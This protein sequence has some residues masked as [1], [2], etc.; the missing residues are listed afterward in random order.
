MSNSTE[1]RVAIVAGC[2][3]PFVRAGGE[4]KDLGAVEM[5]RAAVTELI[6]RSGVDP[7]EV[8]EMVFGCVITPVRSPNVAREVALASSLPRDVPGFTVNRACA[9][10]NQAIVSAAEGIAC[11]QYDTAIAGGA[12]SLS[13]VPILWSRPAAQAIVAAGKARGIAAK[14]GA[15]SKVRPRDLLPVPPAIAEHSTGLTMGQSAEKMAKENRI[16]REEQDRFA[17]ASHLNAAKGWETGVLRAETVTVWAPPKFD[18]HCDRDNQIRADTTY[19]ALAKLPPVF[20]RRHGSVTAGNTSPLT[21]GA[22][23]VLLMAGAK[24]RAL[25]IEPLGY[26]RSYAFAATDPWGQLLMG[27][28]YAA[29]VALDRAN[30][31]LAEM[32]LIEMHEA[33]AVQVLSNIQAFE[34]AAFAREKLGRDKPLGEVDRS[35]LNVHGGSIALGHPFGATGARMVTQLLCELK[36]RNGRFGL[37]TVCAQGGMGCAMVL[38]R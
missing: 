34:S 14:V 6:A 35:K 19:E 1:R 23:A 18:R 24:A 13:E 30:L 36:R 3:T 22:A 15:F 32:D 33:F 20:D 11:G 9:S 5:G 7:R 31:T 28:A 25:G 16:G 27:P 26:I 12:E 4:F 17:L 37:L 38:E 8:R 21:D 10:A 2:R 29:P